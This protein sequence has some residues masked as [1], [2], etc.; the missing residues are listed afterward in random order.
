MTSK[1]CQE[2]SKG[3]Y[4]SMGEIFKTVS[5]VS[6]ATLIFLSAC[7]K[8]KTTEP[9]PAKYKWTILG[10]FDGNNSQDQTPEGRSYVIKD[11]QEL[12]QIDSTED[13]QILVMLGSFKTD[14]GCKYYH[15][16]RHIDEPEDSISSE[17]VLDLGKKDM[18]DPSTLRN[19]ISYGRQNYPA[20]R[21]MLVINDQG[22]TWRGIC[23]DTI[24]GDGIP[25]SLPELSYALS[26]FDFD[27]IWFYAPSLA[28]AEMAYQIRN[29]S[30]YM[31]ASEFKQLPKNIM[32]SSR[33]LSELTS[34]PDIRVRALASEI[35]EAIGSTAL[36][37]NPNAHVH[38]V[39][40]YLPD[41]SKLSTDVFNLAQALIDSTGSYWSEVWDAW[42]S[43]RYDEFDS[44]FVD[45]REFARSIQKQPNLSS[46]IKSAAESLEISV[47]EAVVTQFLNP[48]FLLE[49]VGGI[50]IRLPWNQEDFDSTDYV[51]LDFSTTDWH[52]FISRFIQHYSDSYACIL[53]IRSLP[54]GARVFLNG[55]DTGDTTNVI[56]R[57]LFP[58]VYV[59]RLS[60]V[61]CE[62]FTHT[63]LFKEPRDSVSVTFPLKCNH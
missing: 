24:N 16:E 10:Y 11:L 21:Y 34:N 32:G 20:G 59:I 52:S 53:D 46:T 50:L 54:T 13:I 42:E 62:D 3:R 29:F 49:I 28:T 12:E 39:L 9:E 30:K 8:K 55:V 33:W 38:S 5:V 57:G 36:E 23:S 48:L 44:I 27:I 47:N 15:V 35:T 14:G 17:V 43:G 25:M 2:G 41:I 40:I 60:K 45:L 37:A 63:I 6:L 22:A 51:Q 7:S 56:F 58:D 26:G 4:P 18:S 61:G 19:F 31:I 1:L